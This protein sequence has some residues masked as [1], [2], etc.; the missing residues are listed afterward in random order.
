MTKKEFRNEYM[1]LRS[2]LSEAECDEMSLKIANQLLKMAIWDFRKY[3]IFLSITEK[4]EVN[5]DYILNILCGKDKEVIIP[6]VDKNL[7]TLSHF[8]LT[9]ETIL[10]KNR[11]GIVEPQNGIEISPQE[12][13]VV[14][15]PLL[16]F[17]LKGNRL[18]YGGGYYDR[19][20]SEC[21][22]EVLKIGLSFFPP[23]EKIEEIFETDI[24][25]DY[26]VTPS[27]I[28]KF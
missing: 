23:T 3:H 16:V 5:T 8:L 6:K 13:D 9:D 10:R 17:D 25:L 26:C 12:I 24:P 20:L 28:F 21:S 2:K 11:W 1:S 22:S 14:F 18:G 7:Q 19:F 15:V 4:K 27:D